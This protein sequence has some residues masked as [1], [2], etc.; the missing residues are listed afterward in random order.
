[1]TSLRY[2]T[3]MLIKAPGY[4]LATVSL[5]AI[6]I[7]ATAVIFSLLDA[8]LLRP[9]PVQNPKSLVRVVQ[10]IP[11][12]R[13]RTE[14]QYA[15]Y[16]A[17]IQRGTTFDSVFAVLNKTVALSYPG[18][19]EEVHVQ[20]TT[21]Q[22]FATLG[23]PALYGRTL[24]A[25]DGSE[26][27]ET[28]PAIISYGFWRAR[29]NSDPR[30]IGGT[31][32]LN[33]HPFTIVGV[34]PRR[35]NGFSAD[36]TPEIRVPFRTLPQLG[37]TTNEINYPSVEI[38]GRL[39][40]GV[41]RPGA[42]A[43]CLLIWNNAISDYWK[44]LGLSSDLTAA[45][46]SSDL[47][48]G[49]ELQPLERGASILRDRYDTALVVLAAS[50]GLLQL[51]LCANLATLMLA[52]NATRIEETAVC[53]ALGATRR[54]IVAQVFIECTLISTI[55]AASG[56]TIA[57]IAMPF[58]I[59]GLPPIRDLTATRL[60][61]SLNIDL[62]WRVLLFSLLASTLTLILFGLAP[63][64]YSSRISLDSVLRGARATHSW[65]GHRNLL[66]FQ[67]ALCTLLLAFAG[68][69]V[70]TLNELRGISPGFD[71]DHIV[72]FT[73]RPALSGYTEK[74]TNAVRIRL[75]ASAAALPGVVSTASAQFPV[76]RGRG[77]K[78]TVAAAGGVTTGSES[79][80]T[81]FNAVSPEYFATMGI[82]ILSGHTL[83]SM[84]S[85]GS[86]TEKVVVNEA[87]VRQ[88]FPTIAPTG[89]EFNLVHSDVE[90][91]IVGVVGDAKFRSLREPIQPI[92]YVNE[93]GSDLFVLY[94]RT[95]LRSD[96]MIEPV[97]RVFSE[98]DPAL[99]VTESQT[100]TEEVDAS[101]A[102]DRLSAAIASIF[103][104]FATLL[105]AAGIYA[106]FALVVSQ[107][108]REIAI[109]MAVGATPF[110]IGRMIFV[111]LLSVV[112]GGIA[113]GLGATFVMST[114]VRTLLYGVTPNDP[115]ALSAAV[116]LVVVVAASGAAVPIL[117][118]MRIQP[119]NVL[120]QEK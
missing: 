42:Q 59:Q 51:M 114:A 62:D 31:I 8:L 5:L 105:A 35:F 82:N 33:G 13:V 75:L 36:T 49:V 44:A 47:S 66:V 119:A 96:S 106:L 46:I 72:S 112:C 107:R 54:R 24:D 94:V 95:H 1:M 84:E 48:L 113:I 22:F 120:G 91:E 37:Q 52:R 116:L 78:Y 4:A 64:I 109:R 73:A 27:S 89:R 9:L 81:S 83:P 23:V 6:G 104:V 79:P 21:P 11:Q 38:V 7:G 25:T 108:R 28:P 2:T 56:L 118:A 87:F 97:R 3:R 86:K 70:R 30:A 32:Q 88:F 93:A 55:G 90:Y 85:S 117:R 98:V 100:L 111:K 102:A 67:V 61:T 68:L 115:E 18:P 103:A 57:R 50:A 15:F 60:T 26:S 76:M 80:N 40:A 92:F 101:I 12:L 41:T 34:M 63:A 29:F 39:K 17:L 74:Q 69:L 45:H 19:A 77:L 16:S 53:L 71:T 43:Q 14:F 10:N 99:P 65:H 58:L 20:L 110:E